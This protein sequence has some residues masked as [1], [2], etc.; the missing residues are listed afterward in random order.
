MR[1]LVYRAG[2]LASLGHNHVIL[3]RSVTGSINVAANL[4]ASSFS[5][6]APVA[7]FIIDDS[8]ARAEEGTD[9]PGDISDEA[10]TGT[11]NNLT[12]PAILNSIQYPIISVQSTRLQP[13]Q[14][15]VVA[16]V[17]VNV[18]GHESTLT[19]PFVLERET[20]GL[21][22]SASFEVRQSAVGLTPFSLMLGAL[23]VRDALQVKLKVTA[24][25]ETPR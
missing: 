24:Q 18:A 5:L 25:L 17:A 22:A 21:S 19:V 16:I 2:A 9:F 4:S 7:A 14:G 1:L 23:A 8:Q 12:G 20:Y 10:K 6:R 15:T 11:F 13:S 3:N